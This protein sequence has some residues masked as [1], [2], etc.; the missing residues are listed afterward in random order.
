[1]NIVHTGINTPFSKLLSTCK[2]YALG[3]FVDK[4]TLTNSI[5]TKGT[6]FFILSYN[7]KS[8]TKIINIQ[9]LQEND[10]IILED[11]NGFVYVFIGIEG[12][13]YFEDIQ[14]E[15]S[16]DKISG[17][18]VLYISLTPDMVI[19]N[20]KFIKN[21]RPD[22][23]SAY[24]ENS[25]YISGI[26]LNNL[27]VDGKKHNYLNGDKINSYIIKINNNDIIEWT[28]IFNDELSI[29]DIAY[30]NDTMYIVGCYRNSIDIG[31]IVNGTKIPTMI[32]AAL[33]KSLNLKWF[34]KS[35]QD[36][37]IILDK[38]K[39]YYVRAENIA[40]SNDGIYITGTG[41]MHFFIDKHAISL[42]VLSPFIVKMS[43]DSKILW[44]KKIDLTPPEEI[45]IDICPRIIVEDFVYISGFCSHLIQYDDKI[46]TVD[47]TGTF[48]I[49]IDKDGNNAIIKII[50]GLE[51]NFSK[52]IVFREKLT[53]V[54]G[55]KNF[56]VVDSIERKG[57][58]HVTFCV[59]ELIF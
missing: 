42:D 17:T 36:T 27:E 10:A 23:F 5:E 3:K 44:A 38:K 26:F 20:Y 33:D 7:N 41:N 18:G 29:Y 34:R 35:E 32:I 24:V 55:F 47:H 46:V 49:R 8:V 2:N 52:F 57:S 6:G 50:N 30:K 54:G 16:L 1:M 13:L 11:K 15:M 4:L 19:K 40:L 31:Q 58:K 45:E 53:F 37:R 22:H 43:Y 56:I 14:S 25:I 51:Y 12:V 9:E 28:K 59:I 21:A 48:I 39:D